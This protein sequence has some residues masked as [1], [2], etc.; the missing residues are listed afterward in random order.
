M[1]KQN[2][3]SYWRDIDISLCFFNALVCGILSFNKPLHVLG[4]VAFALM[5][6][7]IIGKKLYSTEK[8]VSKNINAIMI[9]ARIMLFILLITGIVLT[10]SYLKN[11]DPPF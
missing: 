3:I 4:A 11:I 2:K 1:K 10:F 8:P 6:I 9:I 5:L 7:P